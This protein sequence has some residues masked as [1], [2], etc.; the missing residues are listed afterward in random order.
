ML[1]GHPATRLEPRMGGVS[2]PS[3]SQGINEKSQHFKRASSTSEYRKSEPGVTKRHQT[4][5]PNHH[6]G[7]Q[8]DE[9]I[10]IVKSMKNHIIYNGFSIANH[11][12]LV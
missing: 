12:I 3:V 7:H 10:E 9:S 5:T 2:Q 6:S 4:V 11:W 8:I 1:V